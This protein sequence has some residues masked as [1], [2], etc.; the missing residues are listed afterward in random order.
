MDLKGF[1]RDV[2]DFPRKGIVFRDI[3]PL[4]RS[5]EAFKFSVDRIVNHFNDRKID[6]VVSPESRGFIFGGA[7][8]HRLGAGFVPVRKKGKLPWKKAVQEYSLEYGTDS[9][10]MHED[11]VQEGEKILVFD[12]LLATGGTI[13]AVKK[14]VEDSGGKI[15]GFSFLVEFGDLAGRKKLEGYEVFSLVKY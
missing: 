5:R 4:L 2:P 3:T 15:S 10:E 9:V 12:D 14:L 6:L 8:A 1:I 7:I 13:L 11:A